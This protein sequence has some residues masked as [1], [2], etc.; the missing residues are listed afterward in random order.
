MLLPS[1]RRQGRLLRDRRR[2][3]TLRQHHRLPVRAA[4]ARCARRI[5]RQVR[6]GWP[7]Q[8]GGTV[9][10]SRLAAPAG[11]LAG[12]GWPQVKWNVLPSVVATSRPCGVK[13]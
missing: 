13:M 12:W 5:P 2:H 11:S 6:R 8:A 10:A 9:P 1:V 4:L 7:R 3:L